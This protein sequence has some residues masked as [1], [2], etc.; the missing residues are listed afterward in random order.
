MIPTA[1]GGIAL[2]H[3]LCVL[4]L[5]GLV[6][7][8]FRPKGHYPASVARTTTF[9]VLYVVAVSGSLIYFIYVFA[10]APDF[11]N[12]PECNPDTKYVLFGVDIQATNT[13][14][15]WIFVA[16]FAMLALG[17]VI[18]LVILSGAAC[19]MALDCGCGRSRSSRR[20]DGDSELGTDDE[21]YVSR[22]IRMLG[23]L[24]ASIYMMVM[25]EMMIR[26][27]ELLPSIAEWTFGQVLAMS[28]LIGP[29]VE[30]ASLL[31]GKVKTNPRDNFLRSGG[32]G[33]GFE[34]SVARGRFSMP[35]R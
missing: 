30:F 11:G 26:R 5:L 23:R 7:I 32:G 24:G 14:I 3:P 34:A 17:F 10:N 15:R 33:G 21:L 22:F 20:N 29:L 13:V 25:L 2:F 8:S 9:L 6:G 4:H 35:E 28:M 12:K 16:M 31:L 27:N 18:W 1:L 19:C